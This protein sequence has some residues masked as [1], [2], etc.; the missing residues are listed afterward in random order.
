ME[1]EYE[2]NMRENAHPMHKFV[3]LWMLISISA[4]SFVPAANS[5]EF[6]NKESKQS[7]QRSAQQK[8]DPQ[9]DF[10][11]YLFAEAVE[12]AEAEEKIVFD[13]LG[14]NSEQ[15]FRSDHLLNDLR[16]IPPERQY[17]PDEPPIV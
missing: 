3:V 14:L 6:T 12:K 11:G 15:T 10:T 9:K 1:G 4:I 2:N 7:Q 17:L 5:V 8:N 16:S 13:V